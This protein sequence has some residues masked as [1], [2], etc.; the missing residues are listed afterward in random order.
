LLEK[1]HRVRARARRER[2][3]G[4]VVQ[5]RQRWPP[6]D[7]VGVGLGMHRP[8]QE[9]A[10]KVVVQRQ[11]TVSQQADVRRLVQQARNQ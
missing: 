10:L 6:E 4:V 5:R 3:G 7:D 1:L 2:H 9:R 11:R 8:R